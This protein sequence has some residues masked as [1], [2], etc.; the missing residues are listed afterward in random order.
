MSSFD[1]RCGRYIWTKD[2][3]PR[4]WI[5]EADYEAFVAQH[6]L[7]NVYHC[8]QTADGEMKIFFDRQRGYGV[9]PDGFSAVDYTPYYVGDK[10]GVL[11]GSKVGQV[12]VIDAVG[13]HVNDGKVFFFIEFEGRVSSRRYWES[14][15]EPS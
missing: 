8:V 14:D 15:I 12:G 13:W 3:R 5:L 11:N 2:T 1:G 10:V 9:N 4:E 7:G 6:T